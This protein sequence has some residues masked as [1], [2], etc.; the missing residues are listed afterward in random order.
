MK[1]NSSNLTTQL[2]MWFYHIEEYQ[3]PKNLCPYFWKVVLMF[4]LIVPYTAFCIPVV[5]YEIIMKL[6]KKEGSD[7]ST[8]DRPI[9]SFITYI[10]LLIIISMIVAVS[11]IW[12]SIPNDKSFLFQLRILGSLLWGLAIGTGIYHLIK[13]LYSAIGDYRYRKNNY[14]INGN[15]LPREPKPNL[16]KE[17]VKAKY[18]KYCPKIEWVNSNNGDQN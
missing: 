2:Y 13:W 12:I 16:V 1:I 10:I 15:W 4:L 7:L 14:D 3:L 11:S 18:H 6:G 17:F 5:V 9:F 8:T